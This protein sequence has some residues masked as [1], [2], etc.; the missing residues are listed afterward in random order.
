VN[1]SGWNSRYKARKMQAQRARDAQPRTDNPCHRKGCT[2]VVPA[3]EM[4]MLCVSCRAESKQV[5]LEQGSVAWDAWW[6]NEV[7]SFVPKV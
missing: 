2:T 1:A 6:R 3:R 5:A 4:S 7:N